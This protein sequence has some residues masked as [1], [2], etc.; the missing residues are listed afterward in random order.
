MTAKDLQ[1]MLGIS[2]H[3][4]YDLLEDGEISYIRL[5]NDY[6]VPKINVIQ[7]IL[8]KPCGQKQAGA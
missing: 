5:G 3:A 1:T 6:K 7:Y 8:K 2:C 4:V